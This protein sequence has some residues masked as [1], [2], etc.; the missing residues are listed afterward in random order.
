MAA[1]SHS[2][3]GPDVHVG[4]GEA[5]LQ[6][7]H[8]GRHAVLQ[9]VVRPVVQHLAKQLVTAAVTANGRTPARQLDLLCSRGNVQDT[10]HS[11]FA[12]EAVRYSHGVSCP[13]VRLPKPGIFIDRKTKHWINTIASG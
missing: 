11:Q 7:R 5:G 6:R 1:A 4:V 12:L 8:H 2:G 10:E 13:H 3:G 9:V